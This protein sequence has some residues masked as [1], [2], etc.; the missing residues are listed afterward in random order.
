MYDPQAII[1]GGDLI[2]GYELF[3]QSMF[4]NIQSFPFKET[5]ENINILVSQ[6]EDI[7]LLGAAA[8][9]F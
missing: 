1:L 5:I 7:N 6:R 9:V 3:S 4:D 8:L 2:I